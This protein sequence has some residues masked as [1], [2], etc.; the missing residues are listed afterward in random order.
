MEIE[1]LLK[2]SEGKEKIMGD[3]L[4]TLYLFSGTLWL[5]ELYN[6]YVGFARTLGEEPVEFEDVREAVA[7]LRELNLVVATEGIRGTSKP[8]GERTL[9]I[10]LSKSPELRS[11]L[12]GDSRVLAYIE[13]WRKYFHK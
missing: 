1:R 11:M 6:E 13:E 5:P 9:L 4:R 3:V 8:E 7:S 10:S 12:G 2:A